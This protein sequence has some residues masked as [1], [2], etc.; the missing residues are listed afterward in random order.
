MD[1]KPASNDLRYYKSI[2]EE[3]ITVDK[4]RD[5]FFKKADMLDQVKWDLPPALSSLDWIHKV[6]SSDGRD[7]VRTATRTLSGVFPDIKWRPV[8]DKEADKKEAN[9]YERILELMLKQASKRNEVPIQRDA[10]KSACQ[11]D[12]VSAQVIYIPYQ[13]KISESYGLGK[14]VRHFDA[15]L[16]M[17]DFSVKFRKP[18]MVHTLKTDYGLAGVLYV[19]TQKL[20]KI[21]DH[22]GE[23]KILD[24]Y[25]KDKSKELF[26]EY[27]VYDYIDNNDRAV[28]IEAG[29][30]D[31][32]LLLCKNELPFMGDWVIKSGGSNMDE[33]SMYMYEPLNASIIL[34]R[35]WETQN[36]VETLGVSSEIFKAAKPGAIVTGPGADQVEVDYTDPAQAVKVPA[37]T[38][39][40]PTQAQ[41][42]DPAKF[43]LADRISDRMNRTSVA[44]IMQDAQM[45]S[46]T[47]FSAINSVIGIA[48]TMLTPHRILAEEALAGILT[49]MVEWVH[50]SK[51]PIVVVGDGRQ[52]ELDYTD[53]GAEYILDPVYFDPKDVNISVELTSDM[54]MDRQSKINAAAAAVNTLHY[55]VS[56][57]LEDIG[58]KDPEMV[59][60]EWAI[61]QIQT[62]LIEAEKTRIMG[63]AQAEV[64]AMVAQAQ[65]QIQQAQQ[66]QQM[67]AQQSQMQSQDYNMQGTNTGDM[68][69]PGQGGLPPAMANDQQT[70]EQQTGF[71]RAGEEINNNVG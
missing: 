68:Y 45:P 50:Y 27:T 66:E 28:W 59:E 63:Q 21:R 22:W 13:K 26:T 46:N 23:T 9:R 25:G 37:G 19:T 48:S 10:V 3:L 51:E 4:G 44:R 34:S 39:Y 14:D 56:R 57:A 58:I 18:A 40:Q 38:T 41:P 47:A 67:A 55:P 30:G 12:M 29:K 11:Y 52:M 69:N 62:T 6:V 2:K 65:M 61:D 1:I 36:I 54:P 71:S 49:R 32:E 53:N 64:Q 43:Q 8:S 24:L 17:G 35:Q 60:K 15:A 5:E 42:S 31:I 7:S 33:D 70:F 20:Y 16:R